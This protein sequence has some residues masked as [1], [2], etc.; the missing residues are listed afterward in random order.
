MIKL[1][2]VCCAEMRR[3][4]KELKQAEFF[5]IML[6]TEKKKKINVYN[7]GLQFYGVPIKSHLMYPVNKFSTNS[8]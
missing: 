1:H 3:I 5:Y 4:S 2:S 7:Y 6:G 8:P